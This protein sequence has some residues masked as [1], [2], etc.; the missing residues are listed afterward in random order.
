MEYTDNMANHGFALFLFYCL[1]I[2]LILIFFFLCFMFSGGFAPGKEEK[3]K[4]DTVRDVTRQI[5]I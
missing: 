5:T 4:R 3:R 1:L 2:L